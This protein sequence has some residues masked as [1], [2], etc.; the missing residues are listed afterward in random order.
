L[1]KNLRNISKQHI[2]Y[3]A[4][5]LGDFFEWLC[6][7]RIRLPTEGSTA[8]WFDSGSLHNFLF[9]FLRLV[10][11]CELG[12]Y[13]N[14]PVSLNKIKQNNINYTAVLQCRL[15]TNL[16]WFFDLPVNRNH[17]PGKTAGQDCRAR[18]PGKTAG[19]DCRARLPGKTAG[20]DCL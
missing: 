19:Q 6:G 4:D 17:L 3:K 14:L 11:C 12:K 15:C 13:F 8:S 1:S 2:K 9:N 18:L 7:Q 5:F 10:Q 20:Q 16:Y